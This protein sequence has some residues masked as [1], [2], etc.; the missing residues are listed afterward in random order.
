MSHIRPMQ[1][2]LEDVRMA[3]KCVSKRSFVIVKKFNWRVFAKHV[4]LYLLIKFYL[5]WEAFKGKIS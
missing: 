2:C 1:S 3:E 4:N 5:K